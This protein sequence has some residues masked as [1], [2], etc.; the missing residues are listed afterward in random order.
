[1][2]KSAGSGI[3]ADLRLLGITASGGLCANASVASLY[4]HALRR[5]EG[6]LGAS[7]QFVVLTG[8][9]TERSPE[10]RFFVREP[11]SENAIDW[12]ASNRAIDP[13]TFDALFERVAAYLSARECFAV[14]AYLV[15][16]ERDRIGVRVVSDL[17]WHALFARTIFI[18]T[19]T[20]ATIEAAGD[21]AG[22]RDFAPEFTIVDAA[23]FHAEPARDGTRSET[24]VLVHFGR[25]LVLIGGTSFAGEIKK[26]AFTVVN[27]LAPLRDMLPMH[28]SANASDDESIALYFGVSGSGK[29]TLAADSGGAFIGDDEHVWTQTGIANIEAGCY[30][31]VLDLDAGSAPDIWAATHRFGTVL[32]N[33]ACDSETREID[34]GSRAITDNP[35][36]AYPVSHVRGARTNGV[37][38][39]PRSIVILTSDAFGVLPPIAKLTADQA[40]YHFLS[41]YTA[42]PQIGA[43]F[44]DV[45]PVATFSSCFGAGFMTH[46]PSVYANLL[47]ERI[48]R[49]DVVCWLVNTGWLGGPCGAGT[50]IPIALTR[51]LLGL[52]LGGG[53]DD[54][55]F[56]TDPIFG[57]RFPRAVPGIPEHVLD[58][59]AAW[60]DP[61]AYDRQATL[62]ARLFAANF[63]AFETRASD[64]VRECAVTLP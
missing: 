21:A 25:R 17:A 7:G 60:S 53:L 63:A 55:P 35:R 14:D 59:R 45:C 3:A 58:P 13:A 19:A 24:F 16:D 40:T 6:K 5:G 34:L 47:R 61:A 62:L 64:G 41:G 22:E 9:H 29:S 37:A 52:A 39:H 11:S 20:G 33:V 56:A 28:C 57:L 18:E 1:V 8:R 12:S 36:A 27:H 15:A 48:E 54:A 30:A 38:A 26:A 49:H 31:G 23:G 4:E 44:G 42:E 10:D 51:S 46:H 2:S 43:D 32:E 50:R